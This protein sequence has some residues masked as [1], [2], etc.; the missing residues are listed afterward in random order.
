VQVRGVAGLPEKIETGP[1][2]LGI[3]A[4]LIV[5]PVIEVTSPVTVAVQVVDTD[6]EYEPHE[7][8]VD[9]TLGTVTV[10]D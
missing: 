3:W 4:Q 6:S 1:T 10:R 8:T 9:V 7:T 2:A 5:S